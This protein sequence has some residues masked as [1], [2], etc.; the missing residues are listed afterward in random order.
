MAELV[1]ESHEKAPV[2]TVCFKDPF[3]ENVKNSDSLDSYYCN[4]W[5]ADE[6]AII[7]SFIKYR[8]PVQ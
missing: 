5:R 4:L 6:E 8:V 7:L 1:L 2:W 3:W